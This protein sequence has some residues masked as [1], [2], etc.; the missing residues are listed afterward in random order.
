MS[1]ANVVIMPDGSMKI[2]I[3]EGEF[4]DGKGRLNKLVNGLQA[5]GT[6]ITSISPVEQHRHDGGEAQTHVVKA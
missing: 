1:L 6:K 2:V 5:S 3:R 4:E